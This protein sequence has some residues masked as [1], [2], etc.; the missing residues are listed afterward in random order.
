MKKSIP[1]WCRLGRHAQLCHTFYDDNGDY[2]YIC[3]R[4]GQ[5]VA[6][7]K[8][9]DIELSIIKANASEFYDAFPGWQPK[10]KEGKAAWGRR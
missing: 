6:R 3:R 4:C 8:A 9:V 1:F 7:V 2:V 10:T 5:E